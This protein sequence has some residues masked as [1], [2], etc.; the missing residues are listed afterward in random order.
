MLVDMSAESAAIICAMVASPN[1]K[2]KY[3]GQEIVNAYM[4][5]ERMCFESVNFSGFAEFG[6]KMDLVIEEIKVK[7]VT[8]NLFCQ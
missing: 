7:D 3:C 5:H 6:H 2:V 8:S 4:G 1:H